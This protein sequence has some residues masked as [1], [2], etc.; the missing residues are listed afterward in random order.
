[1][2]KMNE[3]WAENELKWNQ[4]EVDAFL[5]SL[6]DKNKKKKKKEKK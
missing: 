1:M 3:F 2:S 4:M 5:D 6:E